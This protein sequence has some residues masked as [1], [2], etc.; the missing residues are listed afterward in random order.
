MTDPVTVVL[1]V[2]V[3]VVALAASVLG[4]GPVTQGGM[5]SLRRISEPTRARYLA[6]AG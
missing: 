1:V 3:W 6:D 2:L 5:Q 4:G